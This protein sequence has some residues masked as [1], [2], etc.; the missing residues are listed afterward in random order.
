[1]LHNGRPEVMGSVVPAEAGMPAPFDVRRAWIWVAYS[2]PV[3]SASSR[4]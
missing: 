2:Q 1:V 4:A 3:I